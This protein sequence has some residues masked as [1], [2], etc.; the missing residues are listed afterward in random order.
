M[1]MTMPEDED[2][3]NELEALATELVSEEEEDTLEQLKKL[4]RA[5]QREIAKLLIQQ[6]TFSGPIPHPSILKGFEEVAPGT[7]VKVIQNALDES[8]HRRDMDRQ[9][10]TY[11]ARDSKMGVLSGLAIGILGIAAG[12]LIIYITD[13]SVS[14]VFSGTAL[15]G[16]TLL[17]MVKVFVL[18]KQS[19]DNNESNNINGNGSNNGNSEQKHD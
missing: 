11:T 7:A 15:S 17:G 12:V 3:L 10:I 4:P 1:N 2:R 16:G 13:G 18:G 19:S 5:E 9:A 6:E 8:E 14:G